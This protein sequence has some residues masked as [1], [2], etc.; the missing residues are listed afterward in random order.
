MV[1][2]TGKILSRVMPYCRFHAA[3]CELAQRAPIRANAARDDF[4]VAQ[5]ANEA[6]QIGSTGALEPLLLQEAGVARRSQQQER[7]GKLCSP[8]QSRF[9]CE[10]KGMRDSFAL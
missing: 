10:R 8:K 1:P 7:G 4:R 6:A 9:W 5:R 3:Q 2:G